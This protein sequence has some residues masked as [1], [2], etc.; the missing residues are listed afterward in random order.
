MCLNL[1]MENTKDDGSMSASDYNKFF[2]FVTFT[3]I[4]ICVFYKVMF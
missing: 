4:A 1:R 2:V 3:G